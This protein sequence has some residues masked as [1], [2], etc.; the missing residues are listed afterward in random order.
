MDQFAEWTFVTAERMNG[1][2][3]YRPL[4]AMNTE[5]VRIQRLMIGERSP[6]GAAE[7]LRLQGSW[8]AQ[9]SCADRNAREI[10][11]RLLTQPAFVRENEVESLIRKGFEAG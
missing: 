6:A 1:V 3:I 11:Q 5:V 9:A 10:F 4:A 7:K 2:K 8:K